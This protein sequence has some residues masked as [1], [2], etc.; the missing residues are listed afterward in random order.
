MRLKASLLPGHRSRTSRVAR[1]VMIAVLFLIVLLV[2]C[3][4]YMVYHSLG[5]GN[6]IFPLET[7]PVTDPSQPNR[8][9]AHGGL[10]LSPSPERDAHAE[11]AMP[12][13]ESLN[14]LV[15]L[16]KLYTAT[17]G[18][19]VNT[20][21]LR[22]PNPSG[23]GAGGDDLPAELQ[24]AGLRELYANASMIPP[25]G[26]G[27]TW[28]LD[29]PAVIQTEQED[30]VER[31]I[32][33]VQSDESLTPLRVLSAYYDPQSPRSLHHLAAAT[34]KSANDDG[35]A[36]YIQ[37]S[38]TFYDPAHA[39]RRGYGAEGSIF[40]GVPFTLSDITADMIAAITARATAP[41][42]KNVDPAVEADARRSPLDGG[43]DAASVRDT[44]GFRE[45]HRTAARCAVTVESLLRH[46][47]HASAITVG[48]IDV[49]VVSG[50]TSAEET[51]LAMPADVRLPIT[52]EERQ[53]LTAKPTRHYDRITCEP[54]DFRSGWG[55]ASYGFYWRDN[56]R[57]RRVTVPLMQLA[58]ADAHTGAPRPSFLDGAQVGRYAVLQLYRGESYVFLLRPGSLA[59]PRWDLKLRL[60]YLRTPR[61]QRA[62]LSSRPTPAVLPQA[63]AAVTIKT[64][65][66]HPVLPFGLLTSAAAEGAGGGAGIIADPAAAATATTTNTPATDWMYQRLLATLPMDVAAWLGE[67]H[68]EAPLA[69][70][71]VTPRWLWP[72]VLSAL[73]E[74]R[75]MT[76]NT[77]ASPP[78]RPSLQDLFGEEAVR[79]ILGPATS[80]TAV[81]DV[82]SSVTVA[83]VPVSATEPNAP[84]KVL[85]SG[86]G[87]QTRTP[88]PVLETSLTPA[89]VAK[90]VFL[91]EKRAPLPNEPIVDMKELLVENVS[92]ETVSPAAAA[93]A[94]T[95]GPIPCGTTGTPL[96]FYSTAHKA[97]VKRAFEFCWLQ[98]HRGTL[99]PLAVRLARSARPLTL[100]TTSATN[101]EAA[102]PPAGGVKCGGNEDVNGL[103]WY[104]TT[105]ADR[106][107]ASRCLSDMR[108]L[109]PSDPPLLDADGTAPVSLKSWFVA[110]GNA[111]QVRGSG[112]LPA[113]LNAAV[114]EV[115]ADARATAIAT[116][117]AAG[118]EPQAAAT[119][120]T[121]YVL[122]SAASADLLFA[123]AEAF[124]P[125]SP[126]DR[127]RTRAQSLEAQLRQ[128]KAANGGGTNGTSAAQSDYAETPEPIVLDPS[129][130]YLDSGS[131]D[132]YVTTALWTRGWNVFGLTEAVI[133]GDAV[134]TSTTHT[135]AEVCKIGG[136]GDAASVVVPEVVAAAQ[137]FGQKKL[138]AVLAAH[139]AAGTPVGPLMA[140][141]NGLNTTVM[142][143]RFPL[144][145]TL[146]DFEAFARVKLDDLRPK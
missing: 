132:L 59:L 143:A 123:P 121:P 13:S 61:H 140:S 128:R 63:L 82:A 8:G 38:P 70:W 106:V 89:E 57:Q 10:T 64:W 52:L 47:H 15:Q 33:P 95:G 73:S 86:V 120:A 79:T 122:Q 1:R 83:D 101:G 96:A 40:V 54:P 39:A 108:Y 81:L 119:A 72:T 117:T 60:L 110:S 37:R 125:I 93:A 24:L 19:A 130:H 111:G 103:V 5:D 22:L 41:P 7:L 66:A 27:R 109:D 34:E 144:R 74:W 133:A 12:Y 146:S 49:V 53:N 68:A 67:A 142:V 48:T 126:E 14:E 85:L 65:A 16:L 56:L 25:A 102:P 69:L 21:Q 105:V 91:Q 43:D 124:F 87:A 45:V 58:S 18:V 75:N 44:D 137:A 116:N 71:L 11:G 99:R 97:L 134:P 20:T 112:A 36:A 98:R 84:A 135:E 92:V 28:M 77:A 29:D 90:L 50:V 51:D 31:F 23:G 46:A 3:L 17:R 131:L 26:A 30:Y 104:A 100:L 4:G 80:A 32:A 78:L 114:A 35:Y 141:E 129:L 94:A 88:Q 2:A 127:L 107:E 62:V 136:G 115:N 113:R 6:G 139:R 55:D 138:W 42:V 145:R 118:G 9:G 76:N